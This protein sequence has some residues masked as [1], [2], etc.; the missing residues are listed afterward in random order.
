MTAAGMS[1]DAM[2]MLAEAL[3]REFGEPFLS[4]DQV[5]AKLDKDSD[6]APTI[7]IKIGKRDIE[8]NS[9]M[10]VICAGTAIGYPGVFRQS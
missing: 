5:V 6:G 4:K 10:E 1:Y 9:K 8:L 3:S 7:R 2:R